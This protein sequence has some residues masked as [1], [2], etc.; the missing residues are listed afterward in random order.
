MEQFKL[1]VARILDSTPILAAID[2]SEGIFHFVADAAKAKPGI[3]VTIDEF[4]YLVD[5]DSA[6]RR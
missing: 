6:L 3:V 1:E 2:S 5:Q 4:P